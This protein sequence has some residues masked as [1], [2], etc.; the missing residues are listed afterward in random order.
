[1]TVAPIAAPPRLGLEHNG[2]CMSVEE[3]DAIDDYDD[4]YTYELIHG[5]LVVNPIPLAQ[6]RGPNHELG[7]QLLNYCDWHAKGKSLDDTLEEE[8]VRTTIGRRRADR[9]IW[10]GLG[11]Q[12]KLKTDT[13]SIVVE[14]VS[15]GRKSWQRDYV[16]KR[17]EYLPLGVIEYWVL[18]RFDRTMTVFRQPTPGKIVEQVVTE[19]EIYRSEL[20]PGFELAIATLFAV[21]DRWNPN[22]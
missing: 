13:P 12:P 19:P 15:A 6:E 2:I 18:N 5:V 1:M 20:L 8:Y 16:E 11:R 22:L 7:R 17:D 14:F 21:A 3:F 4:D 9:V 10:T